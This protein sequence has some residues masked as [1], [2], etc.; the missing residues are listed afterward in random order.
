MTDII[1]TIPKDVAEEVETEQ[2]QKPKKQR[3][4]MTELQK[5]TV[6]KNFEKG[7]ATLALKKQ[8]RKKH[9]KKRLMLW[10]YKKRNN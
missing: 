5:E 3:K 2:I 8:S 1:E 6:K 7:R 10:Y 4:P 9:K